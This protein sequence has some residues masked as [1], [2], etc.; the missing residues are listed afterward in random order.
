MTARELIEIREI[1]LTKGFDYL[2]QFIKDRVQSHWLQVQASSS[3][4]TKLLEREQAIGA[5]LDLTELLNDFNAHVELKL[6]EATKKE[7][8]DA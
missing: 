7:E 8:Q 2:S 1:K 5:A 4:L 3:D 6:K